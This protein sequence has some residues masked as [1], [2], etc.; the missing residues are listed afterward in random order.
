MNPTPI[1]PRQKPTSITAMPGKSIKVHSTPSTSITLPSDQ[2]EQTHIQK[3]D[4]IKA[5]I[6]QGA[7]LTSAEGL[8]KKIVEGG[9][10]D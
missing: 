10:L 9:F 4:Q 5:Q 8:A 2:H 6:A 3:L 1:D 7:Y